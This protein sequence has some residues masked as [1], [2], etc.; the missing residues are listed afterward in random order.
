V[1]QLK[2]ETMSNLVKMKELMDGYS[3]TL[4]L[5]RFSTRK[6][7]PLHRKLQNLYR[8]NKGFQSH[9]RKLKAELQHFQDEVAQRNL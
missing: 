9:N 7:N 3:H 6:V 1:A 5:E 4:D 2:T 8:Q